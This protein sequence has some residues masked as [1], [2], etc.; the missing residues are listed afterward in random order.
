M[1]RHFLSI[2]DL[3]KEEFIALIERAREL[4]AQK[5]S[6][7]RQMTLEGKSIA[8]IFEKL[9]TRTRVSFEVG[10]NDL[11][12]HVLYMNPSDMQLGR[13]ETIEDTAKILSLYL[14]G[15]IIRTFEQERI[16]EFA[17]HA[18]VPVI[19]AL[20]NLEHPT[21]I[22]SDLMTVAEKGIDIE[23]FKLAYIGD[24]NNIVNSLIGA[25]GVLGFSI[26]AAVP[27]GYEPDEY[28]VEKARQMGGVVE[29]LSDPVQAAL[30]AQ[31]LYTDVWVSMGQEEE[32]LKRNELFRPYQIN[33]DLIAAAN[34]NAVV[35]HCLPAHRGEEITEEALTGPSSIVF[36]QAENKLHA[37]KAILEMFMQGK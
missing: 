11:G 20:T 27:E 4:K 35:M 24:G 13:G 1:S 25:S 8:L 19:N 21:Q 37:G 23:N 18:S 3:S 17:A 6:G 30:G 2:F 14:D 31:V 26:A 32:S 16:D 10:I 34:E 29:I 33:A 5:K 15:A 12:G 28:I 36:E 7:N 22:V 9:S